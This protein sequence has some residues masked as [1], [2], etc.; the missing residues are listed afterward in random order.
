[1]A[2]MFVLEEWRFSYYH[3]GRPVL[4]TVCDDD[5]DLSDAAVVCREMGCGDAIAAKSAAYFGQG[6]GPVWLYDVNCTGNELTLAA[7]ESKKTEDYNL[8]YKDAGVICQCK[9]FHCHS[10]KNIENKILSV[11]S[12]CNMSNKTSNV[13]YTPPK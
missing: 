7:C 3:W 1:M 2:S 11:Y 6:G 13:F 10:C 5:W 8:H 12:H 4:G 9:L